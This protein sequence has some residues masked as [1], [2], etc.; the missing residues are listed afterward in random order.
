MD[1]HFFLQ[2]EDFHGNLKSSYT[3]LRENNQF[4]DVTLCCEGGQQVKAHKIILSA[5]SSLLNDILIQN[6]HPKPLIY[7]RGIKIEQLNFLVDFMYHGEVQVP[8]STLQEFMAIAEDFKIKGLTGQKGINEE[9]SVKFENN[10]EYSVDEKSSQGNVSALSE[11]TSNEDFNDYD[12]VKLETSIEQQ[13]TSVHQYNCETCG[14]FSKTNGGLDKHI[15]RAHGGKLKKRTTMNTPAFSLKDGETKLNR[16]YNKPPQ[17]YERS[18][19]SFSS[20]N[21]SGFKARGSVLRIKER[22]PKAKNSE[23]A[24]TLNTTIT[25]SKPDHQTPKR[26]CLR[27]GKDSKTLSGLI[28]HSQRYHNTSTVT[29]QPGQ[30]SEFP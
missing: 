21:N 16:T 2:W 18:R 9:A 3:E 26:V 29:L 11:I 30:T 13:D 22:P 5:T 24:S 7:L 10:Q 1:E 8:T 15:L 27:C 4:T 14:K 19:L 23:E 17:Q 6:D 25:K 28:K 20:I 12:I